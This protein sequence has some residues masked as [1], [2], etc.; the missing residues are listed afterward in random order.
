MSEQVRAKKS[1]RLNPKKEEKMEMQID[2]SWKQNTVENR[3]FRL[4]CRLFMMIR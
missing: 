4:R 2:S 1:S 3:I